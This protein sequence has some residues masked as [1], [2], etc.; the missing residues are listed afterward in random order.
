[1]A[2][3]IVDLYRE[4]LPKTNC[5][6]CGLATCL[7]FAGMVISEKLELRTCPH[8]PPELVEK[9]Q[10]ELDEQHSKGKWTKKDPAQ[11]ALEWAKERAASISL[12]DLPQRIG[13]T[14]K[15]QGD[16]VFL[17]VPYFS[18]TVRIQEGG[19]TKEDGSPL[20]HWEQV[21][22]YNHVAMGGCREPEGKWKG[23]EQIPNTVSKV[24]SMRDGV[25]EPLIQRFRGRPHEL[26]SA[27][28][29]LGGLNVK[30]RY[31]S[32]D[33]ALFFRVLPM[34]HVLLLYWDEEEGERFDARVKVL[35]DA[36]ITE[37]LDIESM[38]FLSERL[39]QL[40]CGAAC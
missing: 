9:V 16:T 40:L 5:R 38:I 2:F 22:L 29:A 8:L 13:G 4:V 20:N 33:V 37:H 27:G 6:D 35:F 15:R 34:V 26:L 32:A 36:N 12:K 24:K 31:P 18:G 1:M 19:I 28:T 7:A 21:F 3:S 17:E 11:D 10:R 14:L 23:L 39:R 25:E 30:E